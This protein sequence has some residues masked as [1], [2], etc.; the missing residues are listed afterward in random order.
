MTHRISYSVWCWPDSLLS[1]SLLSL[2]SSFFY[3]KRFSYF[4]QFFFFFLQIRSRQWA[5]VFSIQIQEICPC[6]STF[7]LILKVL[8]ISGTVWKCLQY[9]LCNISPCC[10][11]AQSKGRKIN[12]TGIWVSNSQQCRDSENL[13]ID[14][15]KNNTSR[16]KQSS[17]I[18]RL[19][20]QSFSTPFTVVIH[21]CSTMD[22][23]NQLKWEQ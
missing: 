1:F 15:L 8:P 17:Q 10:Q 16:A 9:F 2:S 18:G 5:T 11:R 12:K 6:H 14:Q 4:N 13:R 3:K 23:R 7:H 20:S 19:V 22:V 21:K